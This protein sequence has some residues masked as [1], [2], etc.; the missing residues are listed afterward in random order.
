MQE[1]HEKKPN[2]C[3]SS[4][5]MVLLHNRFAIPVKY[6]QRSTAMAQSQQICTQ[7]PYMP[8]V[9]CLEHAISWLWNLK[10]DQQKTSS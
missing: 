9:K 7:I 2:T 6:H 3:A 10:Q 1:S 4:N 5:N 8:Q